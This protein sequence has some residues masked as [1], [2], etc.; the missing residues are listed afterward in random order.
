RQR[1]LYTDRDI[2]RSAARRERAARHNSLTIEETRA[3]LRTDAYRPSNGVTVRLGD[4][5]AIPDAEAAPVAPV[6]VDRRRDV[7]H[8]F[9]GVA[10]V[11]LQQEGLLVRSALLADRIVEDALGAVVHDVDL[12]VPRERLREAPIVGRKVSVHVDGARIGDF[13]VR[14][15]DRL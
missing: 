14:I 10:A 9:A 13:R 7:V 3:R 12:F 6:D 15:Q 8:D 11:G 2:S 1:S 4:F 5:G